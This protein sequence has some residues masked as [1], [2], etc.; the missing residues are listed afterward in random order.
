MFIHFDSD[1]ATKCDNCGSSPTLMHVSMEHSDRT[2]NLCIACVGVLTLTMNHASR[3]LR[4]L[5]GWI[6]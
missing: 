4:G 2:V 3:K 5:S 6:Q 1:E